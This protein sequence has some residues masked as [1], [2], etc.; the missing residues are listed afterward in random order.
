MK[1]LKAIEKNDQRVLTTAQIAEVYGS[2]T[3]TIS[4]NFNYNKS[5]FVEGK[6]FFLLSG[7]DRKQFLLNNREI[8]D[9]SKHAKVI[10]LWTAKGSLLIAKT[11]GT[12]KAW[13]AYETLV[14]DYFNKIEQIQKAHIPTEI[15]TTIEDIL[16]LAVLNMKD[17]RNEITQLKQDNHKL[18][19]VV[20]NEIILTKHQRSEIHLAVKNRQGQLNREGYVSVHFQ[21]IF[22][23]LKEHFGVPSYHDI[24][25]SEFETA[26]KIISG[27]YPKKKDQEGA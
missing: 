20:D 3:K 8:H 1:Q 26:M 19:L 4:Y 16:S 22:S 2:D 21:G 7:E 11:L 18:S 24:A 10:Y 17:L 14:D 12:D 23:T 6:H 9:S 27:W 13:T 25:R 5:R 15:P